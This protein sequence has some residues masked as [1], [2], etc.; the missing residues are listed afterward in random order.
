MCSEN[1]ASGEWIDDER[2][3]WWVVLCSA[4]RVR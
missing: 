1:K 4:V 2:A 3:G